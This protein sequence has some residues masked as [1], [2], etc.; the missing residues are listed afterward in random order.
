MYY[1]EHGQVEIVVITRKEFFQLT[2][3]SLESP[4]QIGEM[5]SFPCLIRSKCLKKLETVK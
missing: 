2:F 3:L 1:N 4:M 5:L